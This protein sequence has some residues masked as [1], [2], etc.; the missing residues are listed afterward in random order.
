MEIIRTVYFI[1]FKRL[2][3]INKLQTQNYE[4]KQ[5]QQ[6][7]VGEKLLQ[8]FFIYNNMY[9]NICVM[10]FIRVSLLTPG[11]VCFSCNAL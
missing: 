6:C 3:A 11:N 5:H 8:S 7:F 1:F 4:K 9:R 10:R 2:H